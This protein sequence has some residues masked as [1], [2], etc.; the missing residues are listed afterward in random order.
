MSSRFKQI[1][2]SFLWKKQAKHFKALNKTEATTPKLQI[3]IRWQ[4]KRSTETP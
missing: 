4:E 2:A 1:F 3:T